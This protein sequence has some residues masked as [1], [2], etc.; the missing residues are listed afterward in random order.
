MYRIFTAWM[1]ASLLLL[2]GAY[3]QSDLFDKAPPGVEE[4]L[5]A[6]VDTFYQ[7]W[8][9][10]KFRAAEKF[11]AEDS[12]EVYYQMEKRKYDGCKILRLRYEQ[13]FT[14]A[15]VTVECKGTWSIQGTDV[16]T[17]MAMTRLW[18]LDKGEWYWTVGA[19]AKMDTPF[20]VSGVSQTPYGGI[21]GSAEMF[22]NGL[23]TDIKKLGAQILGQVAPDKRE[24]RLSSFEKATAKV[25]VHNGLSGP[26]TVRAD[27][28]SLPRGLV[29]VFDRTVIPGNSDGVLTLSYEPKDKSPKSMGTVRI[30]VDPINQVFP[31]SITFAI[32][33]EM[34]KI[35]EKSRTG[36]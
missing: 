22:K 21:A 25:T 34:E 14:L 36:K 12:Q 33:P 20:G 4:G 18:R 9:D 29:A 23:P 8:A 27:Q 11:V 10:G 15:A 19:P 1:A 6:R 31:I 2:K 3:S 30:S 24:V 17:G 35:I 28:D 7:M 26:V 16:L 32:P 13:D 5:R